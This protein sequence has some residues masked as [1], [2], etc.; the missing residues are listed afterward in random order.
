MML[1]NILWIGLGGALGS[2]VRYGVSLLI[3]SKYFPYSTFLVNVMG[4]F[5]I[6]IFMA[7]S[8]KNQTTFNNYKLFLTTGLCGGFT[9]FSAF[10]IENVQLFENGKPLVALIYIAL[11]VVLGIAA[12]FIGY[13]LI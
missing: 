9:T 7:L 12:A 8:L 13:K 6:G 4:C 10:A 3:S 2:I 5:A 11:S 1:K